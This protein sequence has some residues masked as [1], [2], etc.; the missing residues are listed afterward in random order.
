MLEEREGKNPHE[1][2][3]ALTRLGPVA[4]E[5]RVPY[6]SDNFFFWKVSIEFA[7]VECEVGKMKHEIC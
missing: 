6:S 5:K 4:S 3:F 2:S 1:P 7:N